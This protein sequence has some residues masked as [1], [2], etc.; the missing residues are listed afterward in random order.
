[1]CEPDDA[2]SVHPAIGAL[3]RS[4]SRAADELAPY[5]SMRK[6]TYVLGALAGSG[7]F[8]SNSCMYAE[9]IK[10]LLLA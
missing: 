9:E 5:L 1:V 3:T 6:A 2:R 4:A 7:A 8:L 10:M